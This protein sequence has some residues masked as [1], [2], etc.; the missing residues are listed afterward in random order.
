VTL[1]FGPGDQLLQLER[2]L[3]R[4]AGGEFQRSVMASIAKEMEPLPEAVRQS[5]LDILPK[6]GGLNRLVASQVIT[7]QKNPDSVKAFMV[8]RKRMRELLRLDRGLVRHP[9]YADPKKTRKQW[10]W[11][12]QAVPQ[13]FWTRP[14]KQRE[15]AIKAAARAAMDELARKL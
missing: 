6:R 9:V 8:G 13:R 10:K 7:E 14:V 5:A 3:E 12:N 4:L 2:K 1:E 11:V 15:D